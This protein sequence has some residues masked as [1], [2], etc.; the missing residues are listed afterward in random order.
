MFLNTE[1]VYL[2]EWIFYIITLDA[3]FLQSADMQVNYYA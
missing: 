1:K 2:T 3:A